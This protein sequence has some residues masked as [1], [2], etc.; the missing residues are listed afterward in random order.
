MSFG[1]GYGTVRQHYEAFMAIED[2]F[3]T[4]PNKPIN[5][6]NNKYLV[7]VPHDFMSDSEVENNLIEWLNFAHEKGVDK[8]AL[9]GVRDSSKITLCDKEL[10][11]QNDNNRVKFIVDTITK[12]LKSNK[13]GIKEVLLI[14]MSDNFTR[15]YTRPIYID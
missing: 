15:N 6:S 2:P 5:Y 4:M 12:W 11:R 9:T 14:A 13:T 8:I 3:T 1:L 7:C 10:G